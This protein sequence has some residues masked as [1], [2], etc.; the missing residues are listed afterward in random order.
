V[1]VLKD[2]TA[3]LGMLSDTMGRTSRRLRWHLQSMRV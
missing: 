3:S 2:A 1:H